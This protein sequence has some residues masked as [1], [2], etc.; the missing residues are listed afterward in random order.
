[1]KKMLVSLLILMV[2]TLVGCLNIP[3]FSGNVVNDPVSGDVV[4]DPI[5]LNA[6]KVIFLPKPQSLQKYGYSDYSEQS[7]GYDGISYEQLVGKIA[8][9]LDPLP[10]FRVFGRNLRLQ[11]ENGQIIFN[12]SSGIHGTLLPSVA[13]VSELEGA[14]KYIGNTIWYKGNEGSFRYVGYSSVPTGIEN[15]EQLV[16][17]NITYG[18]IESR[19]LCFCLQ[20]EDGSQIE[21]HGSDSGINNRTESIPLFSEEFFFEDPEQL[22]PDWSEEIWQLIRQSKIKLGMTRD[23]LLLSWGEPTEINK[24]VGS[25]GIHEQFVYRDCNSYV[26]VENGKITSW[27][28]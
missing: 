3:V 24:S 21:W 4:N 16:V 20:K 6:E 8:Y 7:K 22:Y 5:P 19:P 14:L 17:M 13:F 26:Y 11:L 18:F 15:L 25:W 28:N 1:M 10:F 12:R 9:V 23:M 27:Q 2:M